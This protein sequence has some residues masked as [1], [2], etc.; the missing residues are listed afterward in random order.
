VLDIDYMLL[1]IAECYQQQCVCMVGFLIFM[2]IHDMNCY[3]HAK[4]ST[5]T[6]YFK[7]C[8]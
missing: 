3:C 6:K 5:Y 2:I 8:E 4:L 1:K 7:L